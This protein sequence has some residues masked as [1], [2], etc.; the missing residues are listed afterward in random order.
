V[1]TLLTPLKLLESDFGA[2]APTTHLTLP[3]TK[4]VAPNPNEAI[5]I[6]SLLVRILQ[7]F[8]VLIMN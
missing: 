6:K 2:E 7:I 4:A 8:R 5:L 3:P 1:G